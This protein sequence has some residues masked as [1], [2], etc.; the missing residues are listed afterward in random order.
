[1]RNIEKRLLSALTALLLLLGLVPNA[2]AAESS[3]FFAGNTD[4]NIQNGGIMLTAGERLYFSLDGGI[5]EEHGESVRPIC[6]AQNAKNLNLREDYL[7]FTVGTAVCR[8]PISGGEAEIIHMAKAE[9]KQLYALQDSFL[10]LSGGSVFE[11]KAGE[12]VPKMLSAPG[13]VFSFIPTEHGNFYLTGE[14]LKYSLYA[15]NTLLLENVSSCYTDSGCIVLQIDNQNYQIE[16]SA[17][18][19]GFERSRDM[20][21][22]SLYGSVQLMSLLAPDDENAVSEYNEN[23]KLTEDFAALLRQAGMTDTV[24]LM[25]GGEGDEVAPAAEEKIIPTVSEGQRNIVKRAR[26]LT[27]IKWTPLED[28]YQWS[29][30]GTF[31]AET[32]YTGIPYGQPVNSG[33]YIGY[34]VTLDTYADSMLDNTSRF[35]T[36]YS[37]YNKIAPV[38]STDCSG[39]V[40][41]AWGLSQRKTTYSLQQV[42]DKVSDQ[43]IYSLQVGDCL[44]RSVSHVVL[45]S[46][47]SYDCDGAIIGIT[48]MEQTPVITKTT[49]YGD[50]G[51]KSL[52]S[53]QSYYFGGGYVAYR[54][55]ER[56]TVSYTP[57]TA[58]PLD[59]EQPAGM[60]NPAP[61]TKT[62]SAVGS[63]TV[64]L[65]S[66]NGAPI[67]YTLDGSTPTSADMKYTSPITVTDT[68]RLCAIAPTGQYDES[69]VLKYT[70]KLPQSAEP[71]ASVFSGYSIE[72]MVSSGAKITL[73]AGDGATI[74]YTTDGSLP[75]SGSTKYTAPIALTT[76]TTIKAIAEKV[77]ERTS[78]VM[79]AVYTVGQ[80][81][82]IEAVASDG[83]SITP[84]GKSS[85]LE[86]GGKKYTVT[87]KT[88][89]EIKDVLIDG[90][91][92][93]P[94]TEYEFINIKAN[95]KIEAIFT[96][97]AEIPFT[98]VSQDA[99]Y[100]EAVAYAYSASLFN[101]TSDTAFSPDQTMTR[102]M[103]VTVLGRSAG[104]SVSSGSMLGIVTGSG[105]NIRS[106]PS[107]DSEKVGY[108]GK[109]NTAVT[110]L[111]QEGD[112]FKISY[113]TVTG[114]IRN[115]LMRAYS[116]SFSD[117]S[118][119]AYYS[120]YVQWASLAGI[121]SGTSASTF[122][123]EGSITREQMCTLLYKYAAACG[124]ALP[125]GSSGSAFSDDAA[126]SSYAKDAV[127]ALRN[128]GIV[129]GMGDGSFGPGKTA[130]RAQV[131]QVFMKYLTAVS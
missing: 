80:M 87:P 121:S 8:V 104:V 48:I 108:V 93:G 3:S 45:V 94:L 22:F 51:E 39:Y 59:G 102:G 77:G 58:V 41:Y 69:A 79:T 123:P 117:V 124:A 128:A 60:K 89:Y 95:R 11:L 32:T 62:T 33:G 40:S 98:D 70:V 35:Y 110:V 23:T 14:A 86:T 116:G 26:Q 29:Y 67:Y 65:T 47:V 50:G 5:F 49:R 13:N 53:L 107:T 113:G 91:S 12:S 16:L 15:E 1:M 88:G 115:D 17:A 42:A 127:Y 120:P 81:F 78:E 109:K 82:T 36:S 21:P 57:S 76:N 100:H 24:R 6:A 37:T 112:W 83:G 130:T 84:S 118:A 74:Y 2:L 20:Q 92:A 38:F 75:S 30:Y 25:T 43:S 44:N 131:A 64:T 114:Y 61:K 72:N 90:V 46:D 19:A 56:D 52:A 31:K 119:D 126:I 101:G 71:S 122:S 97:N 66:E 106:S 68:T 63:K 34:G 55:P 99:W 125:E 10:Y 54:Y 103:F 27:E 105:V 4:L 7:Y 129:S 73:K 9:I 85:V 96:V 18:F 28:R 111:G